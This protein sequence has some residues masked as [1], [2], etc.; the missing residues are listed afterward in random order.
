MAG[1]VIAAPD[2][3]YGVTNRIKEL[4]E[5]RGWTQ[6]NLADKLEV[7]QSTVQ[8][9]ENGGRKL[10]ERRIRHL[11][12]IFDCHPGEILEKIKGGASIG[13]EEKRAIAFARQMTS[14]QRSAWFQIGDTLIE[15]KPVPQSKRITAKDKDL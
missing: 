9:W 12:G 10:S 15:H 2:Y 4:R 8:R 11:G 6:Q 5:D 7:T 3:L 14:S 13:R 1:D